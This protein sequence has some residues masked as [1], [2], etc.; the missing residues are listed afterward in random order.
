MKTRVSRAF[1]LPEILIAMT[2][3][4]VLFLVGYLLLSLSSQSFVQI[5]SQND[6]SLQTNRAMR[7]LQQDL[8]AAYYPEILVEQVPGPGGFQSDAI[9][10]L[11]PAADDNAR[12]SVSLTES[13]TPFW[14]RNV[15]Y[16][17]ISPQG[18]TCSPSADDEGYDDV[19]HHK[20][21]VRKVIDSGPPTLPLPDGNATADKEQILSSLAPYLT[22]PGAD[23]DTQAMLGEPGVTA[24]EV[25]AVDLL[26]M[27]IELSPVPAAPGEVL[28]HLQAFQEDAGRKLVDLGTSHLRDHPKTVNQI[29][30][31]F[32]RNNP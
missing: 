19:C 32:P 31:I 9:C 22:Q 27:R 23:F 28:V 20:V 4:S 13:G 7:H 24:A 25:L 12:G 8:I 11:S 26:S 10:M 17:L 30:S 16:Y 6:A 29:L 1:T 21:L 2:V 14:Q 18:D 3:S 15:I 5:S